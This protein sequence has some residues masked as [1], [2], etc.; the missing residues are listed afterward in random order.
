MELK[1][2]D[3]YSTADELKYFLNGFSNLFMTKTRSSAEQALQYAQGLLLVLERKHMSNMEK[4]VPG[5]DQQSLQHF[6]SN[7]QWDEEG[8]IAEIQK[9][10]SELIGNRVHGSL[11]IDA[12]LNG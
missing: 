12:S 5:C 2:S 11:H 1:V 6:I 4:T 3:L 10:I 7:S 9:R 8:V